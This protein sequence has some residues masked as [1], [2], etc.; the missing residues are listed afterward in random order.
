MSLGDDLADVRD[1]TEGRKILEAL[2]A[3]LDRR[4]VTVEEIGRLSKIS[5]WQTI[6]KDAD[7]EAHLHDLYGFQLA[8]SWEAGP[9][10]PL[11]Q[12]GPPV[13]V[14]R[15]P[16]R[17]QSTSPCAVVLPDM[18]IGYYRMPDESLGSTHD[19]AAI[20]VA[21]QVT[22]A[23][24]PTKLILLGDNLDLPEFGKYRQHPSFAQTTNAAIRYATIL[25][26]RL[27]AAVGPDCEIHW[28]AGNHEERLPNWTIDNARAAF[29]LR[30]GGDTSSW[31][32]LS[33]PHLCRLDEQGVTYH[34]G[35]PASDLWLTPRLR[36]I[37]GTA[38]KS[39]GSTAHVYLDREKSS[40]IY[41]HIHRIERAHR[42]RDDHD[43]M[44]EIMAASPG[45]L[46]RIDG[47]V[48]SMK[49]GF[50]VDGR[51]LTKAED[52]QQGLAVIPFD[53]ESGGFDY[54]QVRIHK[55]VARWRGKR[56]EA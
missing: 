46:A 55:G 18:Q 11:V 54:E 15:P 9:E 10:W 43:G 52:W 45:C 4:G 48:P 31:P 2:A 24:K 1:G 13:R 20:D 50:D 32:V 6:T 26:G 40:V 25:M 37:H 16:S 36:I 42:T 8:P 33:V 34:A 38:V 30:Q 28:L 27:R 41:G 21:I 56:Y 44:K 19:E 47:A 51:P 3:E 29:G 5:K 14:A 23:A 53:G 35:Y 12:Q 49:Q 7:G 22:A 39:R 17:P